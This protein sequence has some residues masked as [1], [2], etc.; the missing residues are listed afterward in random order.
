MVC[1]CSYWTVVIHHMVKKWVNLRTV[2]SKGLHMVSVTH[3]YS[4]SLLMI[5]WN[6]YRLQRS[7]KCLHILCDPSLWFVFPIRT[8]K[9][10]LFG[11]SHHHLVW[12]ENVT[13]ERIWFQESYLILKSHQFIHE[14]NLWLVIFVCIPAHLC[15]L[16]HWRG[17]SH[18]IELAIVTKVNRTNLTSLVSGFWH[19]KEQ[20]NLVSTVLS[21]AQL[22]WL[23]IKA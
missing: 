10:S 20:W 23:L 13:R 16:I 19:R 8:K 11:Y 22:L 21:S 7:S 5:E 15:H 14:S 12:G 17:F 3:G 4:V 6:F 9:R 1:K 2:L 18:W